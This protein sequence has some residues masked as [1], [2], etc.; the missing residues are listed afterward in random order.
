MLYLSQVITTLSPFT[1]K[2][3]Q[4]LRTIFMHFKLTGSL[5]CPECRIIIVAKLAMTVLTDICMDGD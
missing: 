4:G 1:F 5:I 2:A 3:I